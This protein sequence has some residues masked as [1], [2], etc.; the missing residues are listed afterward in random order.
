MSESIRELLIATLTQ[1]AY[2]ALVSLQGFGWVFSV[3]VLRP[4]TLFVIERSIRWFVTET[5]VGLSILWIQ[6]DMAYEVNSAEDARRKLKQMLEGT[7]SYSAEEQRK[8]EEYFDE[9][10][11]ELIQLSIRRFP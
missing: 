8:I 11:V 3:P 6:I 1:Q 10:T 2:N 9:T 5:A 7:K 4:V